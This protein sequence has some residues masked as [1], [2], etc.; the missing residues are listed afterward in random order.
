VPFGCI[1]WEVKKWKLTD[2][3]VSR[4]SQRLVP[5]LVGLMA[6]GGMLATSNDFFLNTHKK[7]SAGLREGKPDLF[8]C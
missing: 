8:S 2:I 3:H 6:L 1:W 4:R 7:S 5:L